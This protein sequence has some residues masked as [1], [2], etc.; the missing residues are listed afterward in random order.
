MRGKRKVWKNLKNFDLGNKVTDKVLT[1]I[2]NLGV[3][4]GWDRDDGSIV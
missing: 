2:G 4:L 3:I 1:K